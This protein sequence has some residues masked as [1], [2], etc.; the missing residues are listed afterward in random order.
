MKMLQSNKILGM[1]SDST[2]SQTRCISKSVAVQL[3]YER[4]V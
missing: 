4:E 1:D 3:V 2:C